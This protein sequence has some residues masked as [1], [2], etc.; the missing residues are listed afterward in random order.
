MVDYLYLSELLENF[1]V[2]SLS[3]RKFCFQILQAFKEHCFVLIDYLV[4]SELNFVVEIA[5]T[6]FLDDL[7]PRVQILS[8]VDCLNA[9]FNGVIQVV[10]FF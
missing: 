9:D 7:G 10:C 4:G 3:F 5:S 6:H 8:D 1:F 2:N